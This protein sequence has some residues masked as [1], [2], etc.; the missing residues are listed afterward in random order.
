[1][2]QYHANIAYGYDWGFSLQ[3]NRL[4]YKTYK[5]MNFKI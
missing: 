5:F 2:I 4:T 3:S 1:M